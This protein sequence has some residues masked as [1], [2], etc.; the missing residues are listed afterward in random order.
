[1][2]G[3]IRSQPHHR[4]HT[5]ERQFNTDRLTIEPWDLP[6]S[7]SELTELAD[8]LDEDVT[9]FLPESLLYKQG[10]SDVKEWVDAFS[11]GSSKVS[12]ARLDSQLA[13][14]LLL[15]PESAAVVHVGYIFGKKFW[16]KGLATELLRGLVDELAVDKFSG[17][18]H[19]GV[20]MGNPASVAVL[21]KVGFEA[22]RKSE[23]DADDIDWFVRTFC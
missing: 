19:A 10:E 15:R 9:A 5:M 21:K 12:S 8:I 1:M 23:S 11:S 14:L 2:K 7:S 18:I 22:M 16:G 17:E 13:G 20:A 3:E 6:L 4:S